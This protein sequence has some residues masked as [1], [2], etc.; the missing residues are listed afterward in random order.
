MTHTL[1]TRITS[2]INKSKVY[3]EA[4][5]KVK[6]VSDHHPALIVENVKGERF[7]VLADNVKKVKK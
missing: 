1:N 6:I 5:D 3:G 7:P 4:G 2:T